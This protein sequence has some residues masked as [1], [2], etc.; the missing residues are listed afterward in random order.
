[1]RVLVTGASGKTGRAVTTA[2]VARGATVRA[3]IRPGSDRAGLCRAAGADE[4]AAVDLGTGEGLGAALADVDAVYHLAPNVDAREVVMAVHV[5]RGA[6]DAGVDRFGFHSVLHPE[7]ASMPHHLRKQAAENEVR[8]ILPDVTVI[9][10]AAYLDNL[11]PAALAGQITVP[12]SVDAPF[13]NV[14]LADVAEAAAVALTDDGHAG[15]TYEFVG[16]QTL[17]VREMAQIATEVLRRVVTVRQIPLERWLSGPGADLGDQA[18][19]DLVAM[20]TAYDEAGLTGAS[21]DLATLL[22]RP[23]TTWAQTLARLL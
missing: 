21:D 9:R 2:L 6:A 22:G 18:R 23:A 5:A 4:V 12:Y 17:T 8:E 7:D 16:P 11:V 14:A 20:F 19:A 15:R 13:T 10:P 1:M 3:A